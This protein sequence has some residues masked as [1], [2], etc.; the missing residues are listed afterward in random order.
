MVVTSCMGVLG[1]GS[2]IRNTAIKDSVSG[3]GLWWLITLHIY[4]LLLLNGGRDTL[5]GGLRLRFL[6]SFLS[7]L[8]LN[9]HLIQ[10]FFDDGWPVEEQMC[11]IIP[12]NRALLLKVV[13]ILCGDNIRWERWELVQLAP[14]LLGADRSVILSWE[15]FCHYVLLIFEGPSHSHLEN[16]CRIFL[17]CL[18]NIAIVL[19]NISRVLIKFSNVLLVLIQVK[20][21]ILPQNFDALLSQYGKLGL[22]FPS[23]WNFERAFYLLVTEHAFV[24]SWPVSL[25]WQLDTDLAET[26]PSLVFPGSEGRW[27]FINDFH[28]FHCLTL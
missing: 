10:F 23:V 9:L 14:D 2:R 27:S 4:A 7:L 3:H 19:K 1:L 17:L 26:A 12:S 15:F 13:N 6:S 24:L 11:Q 22:F 18:E 20:I 21:I 16:F 25:V 8:F 5:D 28:L